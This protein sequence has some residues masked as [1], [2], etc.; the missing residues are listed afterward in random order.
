MNEWIALIVFALF[1]FLG[2]NLIAKRS[3]TLK[4]VYRVLQIAFQIYITCWLY[5]HYDWQTAFF[6]V[7]LWWIWLADLFYYVMFDMTKIFGRDGFDGEVLANVV[8]WAWWTPI[9]LYGK[10]RRS[11][12]QISGHDLMFQLFI[13]LAV[14]GVLGCILR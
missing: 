13:G 10:I 2:Y 11:A 14:Y 12:R 5:I 8:T 3:P 9:G 7:F 1:D 4:K 6:F